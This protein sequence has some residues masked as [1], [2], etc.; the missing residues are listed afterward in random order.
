MSRNPPE[1]FTG[2]FCEQ[3]G[4]ALTRTVFASGRKE[5]L[6]AY[7]RRRF[8]GPSCNSIAQR[9]VRRVSETKLLAPSTPDVGRKYANMIVPMGPCECCGRPPTRGHSEVHHLDGN[10]MNNARANLVRLCKGCHEASHHPPIGRCVVDG[11]GAEATSR[12]TRRCERHYRQWRYHRLP[13]AKEKILRATRRWVERKRGPAPTKTCQR[14][15]VAFTCDMRN[16][17]KQRFC[18]RKCW[19]RARDR[20]AAERS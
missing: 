15:G 17:A 14:C 19:R 4:T 18:S 20:V 6:A 13:G 11:C 8:C 10:A 5:E 2:R 1:A 3:C 7:R 12:A 16:R 9:G